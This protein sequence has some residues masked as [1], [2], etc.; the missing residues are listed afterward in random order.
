MRPIT[1]TPLTAHRGTAP[2]KP[3]PPQQLQNFV[4]FGT[5]FK[6]FRIQPPLVI[7]KSYASDLLDHK[8]SAVEDM[9]N[10]ALQQENPMELEVIRKAHSFQFFYSI[11]TGAKSL[12]LVKFPAAFLFNGMLDKIGQSTAQYLSGN[13]HGSQVETFI[14]TGMAQAKQLKTSL[15]NY[16][17]LSAE[18]QTQPASAPALRFSGGDPSPSEQEE[19]SI[20]RLP[21]VLRNFFQ[22]VQ[23]GDSDSQKVQNTASLVGKTLQNLQEIL[24]KKLSPE[25]NASMTAW[26][27]LNE[28]F[29]AAFG[30][31]PEGAKYFK[32]LPRVQQVKMMAL[33]HDCLASDIPEITTWGKD[34]GKMLGLSPKFL[35]QKHNEILALKEQY[36]RDHP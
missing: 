3:A 25:E 13:L 20:R 6:P 17:K 19:K 28:K 30:Q 34:V 22:R 10:A 12:L 15:L 11:L 23:P 4:G 36:R 35:Q 9:V 29:E 14:H 7:T 1:S 32:D 16:F 18:K 2:A 27:Q 31:W 33:I 26:T 24:K 8:N 5:V 21:G